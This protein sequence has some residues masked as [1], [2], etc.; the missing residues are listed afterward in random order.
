M[1]NSLKNTSLSRQPFNS[2]FE[3]QSD[4]ECVASRALAGSTC[5]AGSEMIECSL[6]IPWI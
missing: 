5:I 2:A 3:C 4:T 1:E 6:L